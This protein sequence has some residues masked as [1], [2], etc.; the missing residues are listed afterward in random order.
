MKSRSLLFFIACAVVTAWAPA[1]SVG[2]SPYTSFL[3]RDYRATA[4]SRGG[5]ASTFSDDPDSLLYNPALAPFIPKNMKAAI[6]VNHAFLPLNVFMDGV[7]MY[8]RPRTQSFYINFLY[9]A[10]DARMYSP[11]SDWMG[12]LNAQNFGLSLTTGDFFPKSQ[13]LAW[14]VT[15]KGYTGRSWVFE[16]TLLGMDA[17]LTLDLPKQRMRFSAVLRNLG[18]DLSELFAVNPN[19]NT[20]YTNNANQQFVPTAQ[21]AGKWPLNL[22]IGFQYQL[23]DLLQ[24]LAEVD[25]YFPD[26]DA[27][28]T[29][30]AASIFDG[31]WKPHCSLSLIKIKNLKLNIGRV[32]RTAGGDSYFTFGGEYA[33]TIG[34]LPPITL[35]YAYEPIPGFSENHF[36]GLMF[37]FQ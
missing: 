29:G 8:F 17:G 30:S 11:G 18:F 20:Q 28:K 4:V 21:Y 22:G 19:F 9:F 1:Q 2:G 14:G 26:A 23:Y 31:M 6:T 24:V 25:Y 7:G 10:S 32:F 37:R 13:V 27:L 16:R 33:F 36:M 3:T 35:S 15:F 34:T 12:D 5:C